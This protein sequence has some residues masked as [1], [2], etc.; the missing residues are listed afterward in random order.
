L[1]GI[2]RRPAEDFEVYWTTLASLT[3]EEQRQTPY[4]MLHAARA[5]CA[6]LAMLAIWS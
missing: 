2:A 4:R 6:V 3:V 1:L 5:T